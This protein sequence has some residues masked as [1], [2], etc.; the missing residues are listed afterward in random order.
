MQNQT[1][2]YLASATSYYPCFSPW[3]IYD[4]ARWSLWGNLC[5][6]LGHT[7][8]WISES[9]PP[10]QCRDRSRWIN[11]LYPL[12]RACMWYILRFLW[13]RWDWA[14]VAHSSDQLNCAPWIGFLHSLFPSSKS[15]F[16]SLGPF[17]Q[18]KLPGT[19]CPALLFLQE[20][21]VGEP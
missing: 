4:R 9:L 17:L 7:Q 15:L 18:N 13:R 8:P 14:E 21:E 19:H 2:Q 16:C 1:K 20:L 5:K 10:D 11:I 6:H 12:C 3:S